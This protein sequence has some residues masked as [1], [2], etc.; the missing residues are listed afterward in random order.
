MRPDEVNVKV[1]VGLGV[2]GMENRSVLGM[3]WGG[4]GGLEMMVDACMKVQ[5]LHGCHTGNRQE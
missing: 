5:V 2:L 1:N 3:G 4:G